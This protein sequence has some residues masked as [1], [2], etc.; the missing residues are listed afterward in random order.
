MGSNILTLAEGSK[1]GANEERSFNEEL[2][3]DLSSNALRRAR[4]YRYAILK[5]MTRHGDVL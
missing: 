3:A 2:V 5:A 4:D 1:V